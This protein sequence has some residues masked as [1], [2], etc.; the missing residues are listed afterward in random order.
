MKLNSVCRRGLSLLLASVLML[1]MCVQVAH[2]ATET[3]KN[4]IVTDGWKVSYEWDNNEDWL[5]CKAEKEMDPPGVAS[6]KARVITSNNGAK[7]AGKLTLYISSTC[8][9]RRSKRKS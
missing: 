8:P 7:R 4:Y 1:S 6:F 5:G 9:A 2:A 3:N